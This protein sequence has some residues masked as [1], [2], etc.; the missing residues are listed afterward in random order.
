M[1]WEDTPRPAEPD[2]DPAARELA[3][4]SYAEGRLSIGKASELAGMPIRDFRN[5]LASHNVPLNYGVEDFAQDLATLR[6]LGRL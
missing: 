1:A 2:G 3:V 6:A 5:L 4:L